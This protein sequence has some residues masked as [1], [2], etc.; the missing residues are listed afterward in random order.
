MDLEGFDLLPT[1]IVPS[2]AAMA[3]LANPVSTIAAMSGPSHAGRQ[4]R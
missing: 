1:T 4:R 2:S 3:A